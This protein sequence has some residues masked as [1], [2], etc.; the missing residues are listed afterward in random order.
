[1]AL[2]TFSLLLAWLPLVGGWQEPDQSHG[3]AGGSCYPATGNLLV[4]RAPRLSATST[5][6]LDG[7]QEYCIVSH[8]QDSEKCFTCD[9]RDPALPESH[10]IENVIYLTGPHGQRTWWQSENGVEHVSIRLDL[11]GE[12]HFTHLIMK[13]KTFRPAAMLVERSADFGHSWKVYRYF[14]YNCSKLFPGIPSQPSGLVDEVLCDQRYSEIEPSSHGEVIFKVLDPS[15]PV[16]DPYSPDIQ[17]LLRVTNLRVNLTKLHTLGDNLLD[18][19]REVLHKYYYAVDELVLRGSCFCHGHAAHCA[20]APGAPASSIPGMIHGRCVCEHH[21]Q[22]LNCERCEDFYH[23]LPWRPAEGSSTNACRRC[24]CNEHSQ[25]CHFDMAVFLATGN[26]SG[27]VC[28]GCQHN[29]MG[30]RCHL[31]KPFYYRH[32][33]S[34]IRAPTAC[35]PCDCDPAGSLD[36]G[37]CDGH[38]DVALGMIAGQCRC[39]EHVAGPRCDRCQ[40]GAYGLSHGDPQGCQPCRCDPRG[41]VAGSSPCDPCSMEDGACPCRPHLMGRQCDQVQPGFFCA[42]LD[43]YTYEA[44]QATGHGHGHPQLPGA[45]RAEV[46]PDC[47][48]YDTGEPGGRKGHPRPHRSSPR[49]LQPRIPPRRTRQQPPKPDVEEVVRDGTGR[50][51]TWTGSGFARVRDG[52]GLTFRVDNVPYPMDYELLLRYEPE[53]A[54]DWEAVVSVSSRVLPTSP[55]C[56]NLLPSEQMYRE[57]L[58]HSQ[59]YVLLSRPFCFEPSTPYEVTMRLQRAGVTQ[60]HPGAFILID[61]VRRVPLHPTQG[62]CRTCA[63]SPEGSVSQLCDIVSGQCRCQPGAVGRQCDQCQPGYWG[64][65]ACRP[66]QCNGHAEDCDPRTGSCLHCRDHTDGRHCERC[67]DGYY[68]DPVLGSGQQC[69]PCPC[70]GYPGTQHYHGS[71]CHADEETHHIVCL[72]AP[73]YAGPRCDRCSPGYFGAPEVEGPLGAESLQCEQVSGQCRCRPGFGGLRCNRCQRGYQDA[74]PRCS[75]C[76]PCFGHWDPTL[77][78]LQDRLQH[79]RI[80]ELDDFWKQLQDLEQHLDQLAHADVRQRDRL[81]GLSHQ[82]G[83]LNQTTSHLQIL[84]GTVVAAGFSESYRSILAAAEDSRRAGGGAEGGLDRSQ[85]TRRAAERAL[86]QRGDAFHRGA[87]AARKSLRE[88]R[89]RVMGLSITRVNEKICGVPGDRSCE[90]APCGGALCRD[91]MGTRRC[92]GTGCTGALPVSARALSS[93]HNTSQQLEVALGQLGVV[94]QKTQEVQELARGAR[95]QAEEALGRSQATRSRAEKATAQLRA[96]TRRIKAFLAEE[97]ADPGSIE[98]VARQVLTLSLPSSPGRIQE[99]LQEMRKSIDQLEGVDVV[100][101]STAQGLAKA[102][103][104]LAEG[105]DARERA[106]GVRDELVGTQRALEAARMQA[107]A[108]RST[109]RSSRDA[110]RAA[111]SRAKEAERRLRALEGK[112]SQAQRRL[113][114]LAQRVAALQERGQDARRLAQQARDGAQR[115]T[116]TSGTLSQDLAQVTQRYVVLKGRVSG[117]A[118]VSGGA[119]QR[120]TQLTAEARDLLNKAN[121]NKRKLEELEQHFGANERVMAAKATR[122]LALE[123]FSRASAYDCATAFPHIPRGPPRRFDDVV[124]ESRYSD[125]EPSTEGEVIYRVLDPAIPIRDP[126]SPSIQNLLRVT[127]LRVN[128]TKLHTLGDNLL[129]SRREIREKYYYALYELVMRGNCFCYGHASECAPLAGATATTDGMVHGRCVCKHH[130]QGL[131]CERCEDFYHDLPWRPAKGSSTNACR[132]CDCNEHSRRCHFDMAGFLFTGDNNGKDLRDPAVCRACDCDPEGSL[133][134]GLCDGADDPARGLIAGQCRCKEHVAG[135]R[136]DR[137]KPGFFG[138]SAAT[139]QGCQ[140]CQ[141]DP[142]G[143]VAEGSRCDPL[144]GEC[145]CKRL[146]TGRNCDQCL[147]EHWGLSHDL[148]G[149]RPC[150]CDV[151]GAYDNLCAMETG[152]CRCRSHVVGRQCSQVEPGFYHI[153]LDHYTYEAEDARLHQ[154]SVVEREPPTDHPPSWTGTGFAHMREGSWVEFHV[155]DVPFSTE[156]DVIIRYEPQQPEP[157]QEVRVRVLRPSPVSASSPCGNTIPSDDQLSTSLPSGARYVVLPWPVCLERGVSYT[158]RLELGCATARQDPTAS[159]LIDSLVLLPRYSSLEMFIAGDPGSME[160]RQTF[161][162]YRCAQPFHA[163]GPSPVA[164]PCYSLLHSLSA[165]L[166]DGALR[167]GAVST[168]DSALA[169]ARHAQEELRQAAGDVAQLSHKVAEAK[170][171]ADEAWLRAQAALD[172]A[173]QTRARVESSNKELR[174]SLRHVKPF[175]S[176]EGADPESIEVVASRVLELSLP[177]APAQIHR[178]AEEIKTRVRSLASVDAILEQTAGDVRRAGQLLQDA[179]RA[180]SRAEGVRGTAE[181]VRQALEEAR[182]AQGMAEQALHHAAGDIQHSERAIGTMQD[183]TASAEQRLAGAMGQ[184]GLLDGQTDALKV[185]RAN[186]SLAATR[187]QEAASAARDRASEAKQATSSLPESLTTESRQDSW[188]RKKTSHP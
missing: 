81:A 75:P 164:E 120:V 178:L 61:S 99:L 188:A 106:E 124:C 150:D 27:A 103:G 22:G 34:D 28:D 130:T 85:M 69:R 67:Q 118:G 105:Q 18:T 170:G 100:L 17:D 144:S 50:M 129:D 110:I 97:G 131:N 187:A 60:R 41:T 108:A 5:C 51:V 122:L 133:D 161:E 181:A 14:A 135:P 78:S 35:A 93:A 64:F 154:G 73:G 54:E 92:G 9:S 77:G 25:R 49:T 140:R 56:G 16:V 24:D 96:F 12:F 37:A 179:Q 147:P 158:I 29:T 15:I 30:R 137:C 117:L 42:H 107:T 52:A 19:R 2:L 143:T 102:R 1:M 167:E 7:P 66:C 45:V 156:Y 113:R 184:I 146:V 171:K 31:C 76:H 134:G 33:R 119:L 163:A 183:Q 8:L 157:W 139:P 68:G 145:F 109:L 104:L 138:L 36:G 70:P 72:C 126:Y 13:F 55:R 180:R 101:N 53:S 87:A 62:A 21:T 153:N 175:L 127:N 186:N 125:I 172:K 141:C 114:E 185:K 40:H 89:K 123:Q 83:G 23:D 74:F 121:S 39:K 162:R 44:E 48:E 176:Q 177:A 128:L 115:A 26:T 136:C 90:Q 112:G 160:R 159:V 165:I 4:G 82:L 63:C 32:P 98:L 3:C 91:S 79:L 142:R 6:G 168:A 86:R 80:T 47:L 149:C 132:R 94:V 84:L 59:R 58:P 20:P 155:R 71:A 46:P 182:R 152:Q 174:A 57:S 43:Y 173:N 65:P 111:D 116:A 166:H 169:R 148:P 10:R 38:T 151:G 95:S 11:E 88:T